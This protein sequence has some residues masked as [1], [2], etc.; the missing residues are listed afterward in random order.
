MQESKTLKEDTPVE[1]GEDSFLIELEKF[2]G[3]LDLL[4]HLI[5]QHE[6][7]IFD[8]PIA[9]ITEK[10]LAYVAVME[11]LNLDRVGDFL[12]M[13]ATLAHIKSR[14]LLPV[15]VQEEEEDTEEGDPREE[16]VRRLLE[17][18]KYKD[19]AERLSSQPMLTRDVF[20]RPPDR[21][22]QLPDKEVEIGEV[23]VFQ[24]IEVFQD[25]LDKVKLHAPHQVQIDTVRVEDKIQDVLKELKEAGRVVFKDLF[26]NIYSRPEL[27]STFLAV[28]ELARMKVLRIFQTASLGEIYLS[29]RKDAPEDKEILRRVTLEE[30]ENGN[31]NGELFS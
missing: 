12:V 24:L 11:Q 3:P 7:D 16:L 9:E 13:A 19:A 31:S 27:I 28:L 8:I 29:R 22:A 30:Q 14:M 6:M 17:Y 26:R 1:A 23:S 18:Q 21:S 2:S 10:Y 25:V 4:L 15:D 20:V 5:R